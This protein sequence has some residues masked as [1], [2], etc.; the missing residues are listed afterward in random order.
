MTLVYLN[1]GDTFDGDVID[2]KLSKW[3]DYGVE[4]GENWLYKGIRDSDG[5][6]VVVFSKERLPEEELKR[7]HK[8]GFIRVKEYSLKAYLLSK[9]NNTKEKKVVRV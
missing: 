8:N 2:R 1:G 6:P 5:A 3:K 9:R 7:R 4:K